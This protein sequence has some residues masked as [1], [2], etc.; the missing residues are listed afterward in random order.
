MT[1]SF[2]IYTKNQLNSPKEYIKDASLKT[3]KYFNKFKY[4]TL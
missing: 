1:L 3:K 2:F 4:M